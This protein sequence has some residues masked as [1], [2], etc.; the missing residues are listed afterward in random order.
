MKKTITSYRLDEGL[1]EFYIAGL[2]RIRTFGRAYLA[3]ASRETIT[4]QRLPA[5]HPIDVSSLID[6]EEEVKRII[7]KHFT[8]EQKHHLMGWLSNQ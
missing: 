5:G 1:H 6:I 8:P 3:E 7:N 4:E 2:I